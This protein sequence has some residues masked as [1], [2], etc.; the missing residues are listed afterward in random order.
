MFEGYFLTLFSGSKFHLATASGITRGV[1]VAPAEIDG[2]KVIC[3]ILAIGDSN[4]IL[5]LLISDPD[6]PGPKNLIIY[7]LDG[8]DSVALPDGGRVHL[9][10]YITTI[11]T[12]IVFNV[13]DKR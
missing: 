7:I 12:A 6:M 13:T 8:N 10:G 3:Y 4:G 2:H 11:G 9:K 5:D 1:A